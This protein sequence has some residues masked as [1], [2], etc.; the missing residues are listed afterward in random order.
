VTETTYKRGDL[1]IW[2][3]YLAVVTGDVSGTLY[4][5][6]F[7]KCDGGVWGEKKVLPEELTPATQDCRQWRPVVWDAKLGRGVAP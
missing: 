6:K 5:A 1:V 2:E 4:A 7:N 3:G